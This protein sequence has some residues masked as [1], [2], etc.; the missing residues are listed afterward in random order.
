MTYVFSACIIFISVVLSVRVVMPL[1]FFNRMRLRLFC[2]LS[3]LYIL[4]LMFAISV[5]FSLSA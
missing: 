3:S 2:W 1:I 4:F 5:R